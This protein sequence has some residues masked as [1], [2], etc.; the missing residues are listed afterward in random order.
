MVYGEVIIYS[1]Q[2]RGYNEQDLSHYQIIKR[3]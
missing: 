3:K 2:G 1:H